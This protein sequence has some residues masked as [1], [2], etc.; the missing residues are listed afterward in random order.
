MGR[1]D[2]VVSRPG[3]ATVRRILDNLTFFWEFAGK[4][5]QAQVGTICSV[6][7]LQAD[8]IKCTALPKA[9]KI[10]RSEGLKN[11]ISLFCPIIFY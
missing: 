7:I 6:K 4:S 11:N 1:E 10:L 2:L 3:F 9:P 5:G 8:N